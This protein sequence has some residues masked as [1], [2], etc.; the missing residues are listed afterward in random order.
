MKVI[1]VE[2]VKAIMQQ[3]AHLQDQYEEIAEGLELDKF[4]IY[5][6]RIRRI[7]SRIGEM[8]HLNEGDYELV[9]NYLSDKDEMYI[10]TCEFLHRYFMIVDQKNVDSLMVKYEDHLLIEMEEPTVPPYLLP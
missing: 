7:L 1:T 4:H 6:E 5:A 9:M 2:E 8:D 10:R 3:N